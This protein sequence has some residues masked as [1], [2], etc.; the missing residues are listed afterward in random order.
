MEPDVLPEPATWYET[1][2][3]RVF[4]VEGLDAGHGW[5]DIRYLGGRAERLEW[6]L[7]AELTAQQ[8]ESPYDW[9]GAADDLADG[10][11][12]PADQDQD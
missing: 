6:V 3:G 11:E 12:P 8:I 4:M 2:D 9:T 5:V 1:D 10:Q 7:W